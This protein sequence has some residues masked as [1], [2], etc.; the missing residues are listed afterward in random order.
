MARKKQGKGKKKQANKARNNGVNGGFRR[1]QRRLKYSRENL[2][3]LLVQFHARQPDENGKW[4]SRKAIL[5]KY[6]KS[7]PN[8]SIP[9]STFAGLINKGCDGKK[10]RAPPIGRPT[11]LPP[12]VEA[13]LAKQVTP[14]IPYRT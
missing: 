5:A 1:K 9:Y 14:R 13:E 12:E 4:P 8:V 3:E 11:T 10:I 2:D 7:N 6:H